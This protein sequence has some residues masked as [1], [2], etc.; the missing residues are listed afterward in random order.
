MR[1]FL[2]PEWHFL[3]VGMGLT[4]SVNCFCHILGAAVDH[5]HAADAIGCH[6]ASNLLRKAYKFARPISAI[7]WAVFFAS[8]R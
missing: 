1:S 5:L 4:G 7:T 2:M 8:P 3:Q 6:A